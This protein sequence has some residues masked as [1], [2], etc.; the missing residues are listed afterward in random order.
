MLSGLVSID[1]YVEIEDLAFD[2]SHNIDIM[3][4]KIAARRRLIKD[5]CMELK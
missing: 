4:T 2:F 3:G 1:N 5:M